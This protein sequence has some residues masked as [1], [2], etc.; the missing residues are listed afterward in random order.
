MTPEQQ[1]DYFVRAIQYTDANYPYVPVMFWYKE[2]A[3]PNDSDIHEQGLA[4]L[5]ADLGERPV[6]ARLKAFLTGG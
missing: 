6:Y 1:G 2:R 3:Q 5:D 4:L